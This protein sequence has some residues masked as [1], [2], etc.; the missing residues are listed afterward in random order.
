MY[1]ITTAPLPPGGPLLEAVGFVACS[2][3]FYTHSCSPCPYCP[4][5]VGQHSL[6]AACRDDLPTPIYWCEAQNARVDYQCPGWPQSPANGTAH[7][8]DTAGF[9]ATRFFYE[10]AEYAAGRRTIDE[11]IEV[12][13]QHHS[14]SENLDAM[15]TL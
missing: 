8:P 14:G 10:E 9:D 4:P 13:R 7:V 2:D 1:D 15:E 11:I 12:R 6:F 3:G 5:D